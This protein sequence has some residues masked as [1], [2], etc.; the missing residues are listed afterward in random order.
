VIARGPLRMLALALAAV[1]IVASP[2]IE[3]AVDIDAL[4]LHLDTPWADLAAAA[5][6]PVAL[7]TL[8]P[9]RVALPAWAA[10][11]ALLIVGG[12]GTALSDA[13]A[14]SLQA[15]VR[16]PIFLWLAYGGGL[17][18]VVA[19]APRG[20]TRGALRWMVIVAAIVLL[21]SSVGRI[22]A[23]EGLWI[24][25]IDG[26]T[27]NHKTVAVALVPA[28][29][30][31]WATRSGRVDAV[32]LTFATAAIVVSASRTAWIALAGA[33]SYVVVVNGRPLAARR[34]AILA[35]VA[36]GAVAAIYGPVLTRSITQLDAARS[37]H[38]LN[39][40]ATEMLARAPLVGMG[41]G[42]SVRWE[43]VTFPHYRVNGVDAH[44]AVQKVAAEHGVLGLLAWCGATAWMALRVRGAAAGRRGAALWAAFV[45]LHVNLLFSTETFSQTH[46]AMLGIVL[47]LSRRED[48]A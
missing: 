32:L 12:V 37:R 30:L 23:G 16:K 4:G 10:W 42:A 46:W 40:R 48:D 27:H 21:V 18:S 8:G 6:L 5:L 29:A 36:A 35:V 20:W 41:A 47:G 1:A 22:A 26:L 2:Y 19:V 9:R 44:G 33:L 31:L 17:A 15:L 24:R 7:T 14:A 45:A 34:G 38:A 28:A 43:A 3:L 25:A 13:P 39:V 11:A